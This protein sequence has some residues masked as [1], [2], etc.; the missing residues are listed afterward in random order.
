REF[1]DGESAADVVA[2]VAGGDKPSWSRA[3]RVVVHLARALHGLAEHRLI[4]GNITPRNVLI[5]KA[6]HAALLTDLGLADALAGS[7]LQESFREAKLLAELPYLAPEQSEPG[8][9]VDESA[10]LYAVGAV[11]YALILGRPPVGGTSAAEIVANAHAGRVTRPGL[12]YK[13][14]PA[15]FDAVVMKLLACHQEDR[16]SNAAELLADLAPIA[17]AHDIKV[18]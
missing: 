5:R 11:A 10:D 2:R 3:A 9:F 17:E 6:D 12:S 14:V 7:R 13:K 18:G 16:Y 8:A 1:V 4:H 15:A